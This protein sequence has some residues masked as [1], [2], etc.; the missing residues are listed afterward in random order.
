MSMT[1]VLNVKVMYEDSEIRQYYEGLAVSNRVDSGLD[2][3]VLEDV[4]VPNPN[5]YCKITLDFG[6][7]CEPRFNGG[8][9]LMPRSSIHKT[10]FRMANSI[11]LIDNTYRGNLMAQLDY[12]PEI[13]T[14]SMNPHIIQK[15]TRL[16][17]LV[18]PSTYPLTIMLVDEVG[19][20][21]RG[22]GGFGS[23]GL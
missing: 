15:G 21:E 23:T 5:E 17:Q 4:V 14:E 3:V 12:F 13:T 16:F 2:L 19:T 22:T 20:T 18:H 8:Y 9:Y 6:I 10:K 7:R 11:G 1:Y